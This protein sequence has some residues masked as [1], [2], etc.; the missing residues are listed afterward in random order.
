MKQNVYYSKKL[1]FVKPLWNR[2]VQNHKKRLNLVLPN[3]EKLSPLNH[4][5]TMAVTK[6]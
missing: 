3:R 2:L 5:L 6:T 1:E 4:L